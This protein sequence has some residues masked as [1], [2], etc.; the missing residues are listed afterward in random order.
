MKGRIFRIIFLLTIC[1][2]VTSWAQ[3]RFYEEIKAFKK[4]DSIKAP[5]K[6]AILFV[7]SS[8][9]R[10]WKDLNEYF[11]GYT[12][13]NRGFGGSTFPDIMEYVNDIIIPY[14][15][16]QI[17][18]YCGDNDLASSDAITPRIVLNRFKNLVTVIRVKLPDV[19]ILY[20]AIKPSPSRAKLMP[21]IRAA[22]VLISQYLSKDKNAAFVDIYNDMLDKRGR[23]VGVLFKEDS[24]HMNDN[25]YAIW[26]KAI[27][28]KLLK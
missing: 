22:N 6:N 15:P 19:N 10:L 27:A 28:P 24:L 5:P 20:V 2:A 14:A 21:K 7:G 11:P 9:F 3:P 26:K 25:G 17:V 1:N 18:I 4:Q 13:I 23:P 16:K 8:S 12:I